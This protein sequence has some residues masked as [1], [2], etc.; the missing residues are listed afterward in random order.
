MATITF[1]QNGDRPYCTLE[2]IEQSQSVATNTSLVQYT[3][4]LI[5][6]TDVISSG[7]KQWSVTINGETHSGSGSIGGGGNKVL[8]SGTQVIQHN[9]D[10]T[11]TFAFSG[12]CQLDIRWG[13]VTLGTISGDGSMTLTTIP[14][15]ATVSQNILAKTETTAT[16]NWSSNAIIDYIWYSIDNGSTWTGIDVADGVNGSYE[17]SGLLADTTYQIK[18]RV[19]RKDNQL[20]TDSS[21]TELTTYAYPY[22]NGMPNF[23]IGSE[24]TIGLFNPLGRTVVVNMIGADDSQISEDTVNGTTCVGYTDE[25]IVNR[26]YASIPNAPSGTYKIKVTYGTH[27]D[28]KTGG[29]YT[30]NANECAPTISSVS[31]QDTNQTTIALTEDDHDIVQN[32]SVVRYSASGITAKKSASISSCK[33]TINGSEYAMTLSGSSATGGNAVID[34]GEDVIATVTVTDSRGLTVSETMNISMIAWANPSA[35]I[36]VSRQNNFDSATDFHVDANY[37]DINGNNHITITYQATKDGDVTPSVSGSLQD[38]VTSVVTLNNDYGWTVSINLVDSLGGST[39]YNLYISRGMPLMFF[40][41]IKNSIGF[42]CF[43]SNSDSFEI[44]GEPLVDFIVEEGTTSGWIWRKFKSGIVEAWTQYE[45]TN[46]T[47]SAFLSTGLYSGDVTISFPFNIS[48]AEIQATLGYTGGSIGWV[49]NAHA[50]NNSQAS[51]T[52][53][54]DGS[55]SVKINVHVIGD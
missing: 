13:T 26:M 36:D 46:V 50:L 40:D 41:R 22:A 25:T 55:G 9:A 34:S 12:S 16:V 28:V 6:P 23:V 48:N 1:G 49:A 54:R 31:Y 29:T 43:P 45:A 5:R 37:A 30:V 42:N 11:K 14:R 7:T 18:T 3:L 32:F 52:M 10:G 51:I 20:T 19:R 44:S 21:A 35:I 15:Y 8:L 4:T 53:V 24:V 39:T 38:D 2:V 33:V 27:I 47:W 17:I